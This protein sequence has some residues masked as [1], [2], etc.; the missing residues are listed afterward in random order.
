LNA[1]IRR[2]LE[3][4]DVIDITT[5]GRTSGLPRRVEIRF[6]NVD[7]AIYITGSPGK[8]DWYAN[9]VAHPACTFHLKR[10]ITADLTAQARPI[11]DASERR[12]VMEALLRQIGHPEQL[13]QRLQRSPLVAVSFA[14]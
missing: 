10:G 1:A 5:I 7:G 9:L 8:R 4:G 3:Q 13:E 2:A 6:H 11:T 12:R 14:E